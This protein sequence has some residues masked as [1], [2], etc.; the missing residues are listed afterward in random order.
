MSVRL[1]RGHEL[2]VADLWSRARL[3][4]LHLAQP[5]TDPCTIRISMFVDRE[6]EQSIVL[7]VEAGEVNG[8]QGDQKI[9]FTANA[10]PSATRMTAV[11]RRIR[12]EG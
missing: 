3:E 11:C 6:A 2:K 12:H 5:R 9:T 7:V 1:R 10:G 4:G 8:R